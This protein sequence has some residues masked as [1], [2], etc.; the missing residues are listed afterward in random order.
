MILHRFC[1]EREFAAFMRGET[2]VNNTDHFQG[3]KGGSLSRG[4]CFFRGIIEPWARRLNA[5]AD[6]DVLITVAV[7]PRL[8][9]KSLGVYADWAKDD[10]ITMP[11]KK[12]FYEYC[13]VTYN[14]SDFRLISVNRSY[15]KQ[16]LSRSRIINF[17]NSLLG[18]TTASSTAVAAEK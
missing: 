3:G 7:E 16:F 11:P 1:S 17:R 15:A 4:F 6:F 9:H 2:L 14:S 12:H 5:I 18:S 13:T 10:G 8:V